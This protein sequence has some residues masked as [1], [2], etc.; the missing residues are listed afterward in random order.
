MASYFLVNDR[1]SSTFPLLLKQM[2]H[3]FGVVSYTHEIHV[4]HKAESLRYQ[5]FA[6][7]N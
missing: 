7:E 5:I 1:N 6:L 3:E 2:D 4:R